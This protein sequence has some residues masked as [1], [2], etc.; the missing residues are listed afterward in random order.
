MIVVV[1]QLPVAK[2]SH[3]AAVEAARSQA[4]RG[5]ARSGHAA[6]DRLG[7]SLGGLPRAWASGPPV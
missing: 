5:F 3:E 6:Q 7:L 2:R 1:A 4:W